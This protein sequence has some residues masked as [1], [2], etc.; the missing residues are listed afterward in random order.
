M[1]LKV[2][3]LPVDELVRLHQHGVTR[4]GCFTTSLHAFA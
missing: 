2:L 4:F 3:P 1:Y